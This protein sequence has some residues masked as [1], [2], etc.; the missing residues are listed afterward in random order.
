MTLLVK[1]DDN[2]G[3]AIIQMLCCINHLL[4]SVLRHPVP[5]P[6]GGPVAHPSATANRPEWPVKS[7]PQQVKCAPCDEC[8]RS[9]AS[10][11]ACSPRGD[12]PQ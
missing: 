10:P 2:T 12:R 8:P 11:R 5:R 3:E 6:R 7:G 1:R 9:G 4:I